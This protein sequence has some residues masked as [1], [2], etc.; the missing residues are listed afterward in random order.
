MEDCSIGPPLS[1]DLSW[2]FVDGIV[3]K[4]RKRVFL[5]YQL[6]RAGIGQFT[7][8]V[9]RPAYYVTGQLQKNAHIISCH[10]RRHL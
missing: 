10:S 6:K 3:S 8:T 5:I 1:S 7:V 9:C 4:A 2:N